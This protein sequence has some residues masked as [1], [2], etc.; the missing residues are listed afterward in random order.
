MKYCPRIDPTKVGHFKFWNL[1]II[2]SV[3]FFPL[4]LWYFMFEKNRSILGQYLIC[5]QVFWGRITTKKTF[6]YVH[7]KFFRRKLLKIFH[8]LTLW[9]W[10]FGI[11]DKR[12]QECH[13]VKTSL[14][15]LQGS[16]QKVQFGEITG[17]P[18]V[19][20]LIMAL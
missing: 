20:G 8:F 5:L 10:L 11:F 4:I 15:L 13:E 9:I 1:T 6:L 14:G 18:E 2:K 7:E 16:R 19:V 3:L 17:Y 12:P